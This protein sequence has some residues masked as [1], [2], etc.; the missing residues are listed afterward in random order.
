MIQVGATSWQFLRRKKENITT[1]IA[2]QSFR[3]TYMAKLSVM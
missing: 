2:K 1:D 3:E